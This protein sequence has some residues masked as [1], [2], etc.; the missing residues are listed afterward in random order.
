MGWRVARRSFFNMWRRVVFPA[1]SRPRKRIFAFLLNKPKMSEMNNNDLVLWFEEEMDGRI[2]R[3]DH[4]SDFPAYPSSRPSVCKEELPSRCKRRHVLFLRHPSCPFVSRPVLC[5][6]GP[7]ADGLLM[8]VVD[9][10]MEGK[11]G[12]STHQGSTRRRGTNR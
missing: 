1:L 10:H 6:P 5:Y 3:P 11:A 8:R 4:P 9:R 7:C 2:P 12:T